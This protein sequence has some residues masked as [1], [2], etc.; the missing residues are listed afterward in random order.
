MIALPWL[1]H[2]GY[3]PGE[4]NDALALSALSLFYAAIPCV[5][6]TIAMLML[7]HYADRLNITEEGNNDEKTTFFASTISKS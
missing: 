3:Q 2:L 5:I 7:A 4:E 6:K 1:E